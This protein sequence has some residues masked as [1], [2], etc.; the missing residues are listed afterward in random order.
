MIEPPE[1]QEEQ[2]ST[3]LRPNGRSES[4]FDA[5]RWYVRFVGRENSVI[6]FV[7]RG[8]YRMPSGEPTED[9]AGDGIEEEIAE[10]TG[11][12]T[13][14]WLYAFTFPE[15]VQ[16][17]PFPIKIGKTAGDVTQRVEKQCPFSLCQ[18]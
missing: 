7:E 16:D 4:V 13:D 3:Y 1:T 17:R 18:C 10:E 6:E 15:L 12:S 9:P 8:W 11:P 14:G 2:Q 5:I